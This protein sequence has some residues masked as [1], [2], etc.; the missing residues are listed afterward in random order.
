MELDDDA[1]K[2]RY[3]L[4]KKIKGQSQI[5][6]G[7]KFDTDFKQALAIHAENETKREGITISMST[8]LM[9]YALFYSPELRKIYKQLKKDRNTHVREKGNRAG[10]A[11]D[12]IAA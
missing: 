8:I 5:K 4:P 1:M 10:D 12:Q 7:L 6:T 11:G 2:R 3:V 9:S